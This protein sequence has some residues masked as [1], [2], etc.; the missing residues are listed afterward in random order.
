MCKLKRVC[1]SEK[2]DL[3]DT[4]GDKGSVIKMAMRHPRDGRGNER[5]VYPGDDRPVHSALS[6]CDRNQDSVTQKMAS[7]SRTNSLMAVL[8]FLGT[9]PT[10][11]ALKRKTVMLECLR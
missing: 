9:V 7:C 2:S 11:H 3:T 1:C 6:P 8:S 10:E 4:W 5:V